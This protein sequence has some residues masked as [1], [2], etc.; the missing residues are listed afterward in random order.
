MSLCWFL[1][2]LTLSTAWASCGD[3]CCPEKTVGDVHYTFSHHKKGVGHESGCSDDCIYTETAGNGTNICFAHGNLTSQCHK[4]SFTHEMVLEKIVEE[5]S[6]SNNGDLNAVDSKG[7]GIITAIKC[8]KQITTAFKACYNKCKYG[9]SCW[10]T[11]VTSDENQPKLFPAK[12]KPCLCK[13][14]DAI[15]NKILKIKP[16]NYVPI[17]KAFKCCKSQKGGSI[18]CPK[19]EI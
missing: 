13:V 4:E 2:S 18:K 19:T 17:L 8:V 7:C 1:L 3:E 10:V 16:A 12:C 14:L 11:C 15:L 9:V 6:L 5:I